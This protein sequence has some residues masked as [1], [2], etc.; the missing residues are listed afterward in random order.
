MALL[1]LLA[2]VAAA[3]GPLFPGRAAAAQPCAMMMGTDMDMA[4]HSDGSSK[5]IPMP[6]C[7]GDLSCI[8]MCALP[9]T[10]TP[11]A[12]EIVWADVGYWTSSRALA[13]VTVSPDPSPPRSRV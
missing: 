9:A 11:F 10:A 5:T 4:G 8:V 12:T 2:F 6:G 1:T 7:S 3:L 13:G